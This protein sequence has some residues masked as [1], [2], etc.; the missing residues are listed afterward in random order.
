MAGNII[1]KITSGSWKKINFVDY[2]KI[3]HWNAN[4]STYDSVKGFNG[5]GVSPSN[6]TWVNSSVSYVSSPDIRAFSFNG[7]SF[8]I[9]PENS[10][11]LTGDYS[12]KVSFYAPSS[13][14][15]G[16]NLISSFDN[17]GDYTTYFGW[18]LSYDPTLKRIGFYLGIPAGYPGNTAQL[19]YFNISL[20]T[21]DG[22]V[23]TDTWNEIVLI[24]RQGIGSKIYS[25]G[26]LLAEDQNIFET[27][28][29]SQNY[30]YIAASYY[31]F[32]LPYFT[33]SNNNGLRIDDIQIFKKAIDVTP[34][35]DLIF[36]LDAPNKK[37]YDTGNS[38]YSLSNGSKGILYN[39]VDVLGSGATKYFNFYNN[40]GCISIQKALKKYS[41]NVPIS[42]DVWI[43]VDP[44]CPNNACVFTTSYSTSFRGI[45]LTVDMS[46]STFRLSLNY[47]DSSVSASF[48]SYKSTYFNTGE[49]LHFNFNLIDYDNCELSV[50]NYEYPI[51]KTVNLNTNSLY[52]NDS[53]DL[54]IGRGYTGTSFFKGKISNLKI[55]QGVL[56][57]VEK[58]NNFDS[59]KKRYNI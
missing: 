24:R 4:F 29:K 56:S 15:Q 58:K 47:G 42:I 30:A 1:P 27:A 25:N 57:P 19:Q 5:I 6:Q 39:S 10:L 22:S 13:M 37:C 14:T 32:T 33:S 35:N 11:N 41:V 7:S 8:I 18:T 21:P 16:F 54:N 36:Y 52:L 55:Y 46:G 9:L 43:N 38:C 12:I 31:Q 40:D 3:R 48:N 44:T 49:W 34:K 17:R 50:N 51:T 59:H 20:L 2:D 28:Y 45:W 23:K 26:I 53:Y